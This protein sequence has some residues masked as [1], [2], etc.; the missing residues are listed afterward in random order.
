M[1][2][3]A[4]DVTI[5][6]IRT[7]FNHELTPMTLT[8]ERI[9]GSKI[10]RT[11]QW[12][13]R[14]Q[15]PAPLKYNKSLQIFVS[16]PPVSQGLRR[17]CILR[18][19]KDPLIRIYLFKLDWLNNITYTYISFLSNERHCSSSQEYCLLHCTRSHLPGPHVRVEEEVCYTSLPSSAVNDKCLQFRW[20]LVCCPWANKLY[21]AGASRRKRILFLFSCLGWYHWANL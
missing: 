16:L 5:E 15:N 3:S 19:L 1:Y 20:L 9:V 4:I 18:F 10:Q 8:S 17:P 6:C 14:A 7:G 2:F 13:S 21:E 12:V 11:F